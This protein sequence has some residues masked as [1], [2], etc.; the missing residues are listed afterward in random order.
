MIFEDQVKLLERKMIDLSLAYA[1]NQ[2]DGVYIYAVLKRTIWSFDVFYRVDNIYVKRHYLNTV[3][4]PQHQID[5]SSDRQFKLLDDGMELIQMVIDFHQSNDL[6]YLTEMWI[7][8]N[9]QTEK[10]ETTYSYDA[11]Y[12]N[13]PLEEFD[14]TPDKEFD[15]WFSK[16]KSQGL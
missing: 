1:N 3:F 13:S 14:M 11:R 8:Y 5:G 15:K 9:A 4:N 6:P 12:E 7:I 16:V 10:W 2:V